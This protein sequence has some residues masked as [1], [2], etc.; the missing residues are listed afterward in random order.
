[1]S[2]KGLSRG[3]GLEDLWIRALR[4]GAWFLAWSRGG[5]NVEAT[6]KGGFDDWGRV[7]SFWVVRGAEGGVIDV[8]WCW[9]A[10]SHITGFTG[11]LERSAVGLFL[12]HHLLE[13][14]ATS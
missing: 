9:V 1:M 14:L 6:L 10:H 11:S 5:G 12:V 7:V 13:T 3:V 2:I 8:V 4:L